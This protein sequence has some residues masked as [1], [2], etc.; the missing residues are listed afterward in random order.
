MY[1]KRL[2]IQGFKSFLEKT[3]LEFESGLTAVIG[4]NGSGKSNISDAIRWCL[5]EQSIKS[6]RGSKSE[7]IIFAGTENRKSV[8]F[9]EVSLIFN[10]EDNSLPIEFQEVVITRKLYRTGESGYFINKSPC[11]L[12]DILELF[13]DTGIGKDGY[14]SIGQGKIDEILS[15]KPEDRRNIFEE[16]AGIT[17]YRVR[18][19]ESEKKLDLT[20]QNLIRINDI[21]SEIE[22]KLEPLK[23]QSEKAREFLVLNEKLKK[24][25]IGIF[26]YKIEINKEKLK[27]VLQNKNVFEYTKKNEETSIEENQIKREA[28]KNKINEL[29]LENEKIQ[30]E[31]LEY[32]NEIEKSN[33]K[34]EIGNQKIAN[35]QK[36]EKRLLE[37]NQSLL[38]S[39]EELEKE[40]NNKEQKKSE[41]LK[42]KAGFEAKLREK[43]EE[44]QRESS[45]LSEKELGIESKKLE[46]DNFNE[47]KYE[48]LNL[49]SEKNAILESLLEREKLIKK[50]KDTLI[51][52][53]DQTSIERNEIKNKIEEL[54]QIKKSNSGLIKNLNNEMNLYND[55]INKIQKNIDDQV[56]EEK[57][58]ESKLRF[59]KE[60]E[61][62][63]EGYQK[64]VKEIIKKFE[65]DNGYCGV[66]ANL[67]STDDKYK[68]AIEILLSGNIQ[69]I[70]VKQEQ[71]AKKMIEHLK[72]NNLGRASFLPV[73]TIKGNKNTNYKTIDG[74]FGIASELIEFKEEYRGIFENL[75]GRSVIVDN[76]ETAI[77]FS[78]I[79]S[80][81][82]IVTLDGDII[83]P[84]GQM[85]G[86]SLTKKTNNILGRADEIKKLEIRL[87][88]L[89]EKNKLA[90]EN[91]ENYI[92][93]NLRK[94]EEFENIKLEEQKNDI[95]IVSYNEKKLALDNVYNKILAQKEKIDIELKDINKNK[96]GIQEF[97]VKVQE[98]ISVIE[99]KIKENNREISKYLDSQKE[100]KSIIEVLNNEVIDLR[101]SVS[102]FDESDISINEIMERITNEINDKNLMID[103]N[104]SQIQLWNEENKKILVQNSELQENIEK[105]KENQ[106]NNSIKL[107]EQKEN[108]IKES[109]N[110]EKI[111]LEIEER[112]KTL[113]D[114][115]EKIIRFELKETQINE[116]N[117]IIINSLWD[118]YQLTPHGEKSEYELVDNIETSQ[119]QLNE[120]KNKIRALGSINIDSIEEYKETSERYNLMTEQ[121]IDLEYS[122]T[123]IYSAI[124][125]M[126][127]KMKKQF[128]EKFEIINKNFSETFKELFGGGS[129]EIVL[130]DEK[131]VLESG[132]DIKVQPKGKKIQN[133]MLLSGG[134]RALT[135]IAILFAILKMN[136]APF[137][138][139]DEIEAALDD[140][141]VFRFADYLKKL[142]KLTQFLVITHRKG[143]MEAASTVYGVTMEENGVSKLL[144][145]KL[146]EQ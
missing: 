137:C 84:F 34:I 69:N 128:K 28:L 72:L 62:E 12:K 8:A 27:E 48:N 46:N 59:L 37:E 138:I 102:S 127:E 44:L 144:S 53:Q 13:M 96:I 92:K 22:L 82:K 133:M 73:S 40:K 70:V 35:N 119:K 103:K 76:M 97:K 114:L 30:E 20:K 1:L 58:V 57:N 146:K 107:E 91:K 32:Q 141:N 18:K 101:I 85:T 116:E 106:E 10:N 98:E 5:G 108:R 17:K 7:D 140:V 90:I 77:K 109:E 51:V 143:T 105:I 122:M 56:A 42:N 124:N 26:L 129:A 130:E 89:V 120:F 55:N 111:E 16:A 71:D 66:V 24:I 99:E 93:E 136:P 6:L 67:I 80:N 21:I 115:S 14:S 125:E 139:L 64:S 19:A 4:P 2:E 95:S 145:I 87:K 121:R 45:K 9:A 131:N 112:N 23:I 78:K 29:I 118:N 123:Q 31:L 61:A 75:L 100:D 134:E 132:I 83:M 36:N 33:S 68:I 94:I 104:K 142:N 52:E 54:E 49:L 47:K 113:Q 15:N 74:V 39:L 88:E 3:N 126:T 43:E 117:E 38:K 81:F 135:A 63:K 110:L 41:L 50:E 79:N 25:D 65:N 60:M 86:G 11:R